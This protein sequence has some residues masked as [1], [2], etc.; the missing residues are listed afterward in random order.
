MLSLQRLSLV[1]SHINSNS[2]QQQSVYQCRDTLAECLEPQLS[3]VICRHIRR[4]YRKVL[5]KVEEARS[6]VKLKIKSLSLLKE[7]A[8][9]KEPEWQK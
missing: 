8:Q 4:E 9:I 5:P 2:S 6:E 7:R 3:D 1:R